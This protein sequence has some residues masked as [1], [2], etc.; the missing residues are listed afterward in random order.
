[1]EQS[2]FGMRLPGTERRTSTA[3]PAYLI[4][5][6]EAERLGMPATEY[7]FR[8]A[9][10]AREAADRRNLCLASLATQVAA[11]PPPCPVDYDRL[12]EHLI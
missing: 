8:R 10:A 1:M 9:L 6:R 7:A 12:T 11:I 2:A 3:E 5:A 4:V